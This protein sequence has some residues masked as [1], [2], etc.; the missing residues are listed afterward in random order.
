MDQSR[1][2][3][4]LLEADESLLLPQSAAEVP[5]RCALW[6]RVVTLEPD[7]VWC[8]PAV[9]VPLV[10]SSYSGPAGRGFEG[11]VNPTALWHPVL[12]LPPNLVGRYRFSSP[13]GVVVEDDLTWGVRVA[14]ELTRSGLYDVDSGTWTDVL[15]RVGIDTFD[16]VHVARIRAWQHGA[17]DPVLDQIDLS[18]DLAV[19]GEPHWAALSAWSVAPHI[20]RAT[21]ALLAD[22]LLSMLNDEDEPTTPAE[23]IA[24]VL[25]LADAL[26]V[27]DS[28]G[29]RS[30][31]TGLLDQSRT[32]VDVY[33]EAEDLLYAVRD[34][35]WGEIELLDSIDETAGAP[36]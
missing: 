2:R 20:Q 4:L 1:R 7:E 35:H 32:G 23:R 36:V 6:R 16:P 17:A 21:W 14:L 31:F 24:L 13:D 30:P 33:R 3:T 15:A 8:H 26:L 11:R 9:N 18:G 22:D 25:P 34:A 19:E 5:L 29:A 10:V 28:P 12:W 27:D